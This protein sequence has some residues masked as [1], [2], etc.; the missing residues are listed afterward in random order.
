MRPLNIEDLLGR[1]TVDT[2][3]K[4]ENNYIN[5]NVVL[6]TGAGGSIGSELCQQ[7][8]LQNPSKLI[9]LDASEFNL[10]NIHQ[11]ISEKFNLGILIVPI[12]G[13]V[14]NKSAMENIFSKYKPDIIYHAAAYKHVPLVQFNPV[15]GIINNVFGTKIIADLSLKYKAKKLVLI[16]TDKAVRPTNIMGASKRL[17]ELYLQALN[18]K[19]MSTIFTMV[20]FGNVLGSSGSVIPKFHQQ[21]L[22]GKP[23]TLTHKKVTRFFMTAKEAIHLIIEAGNLAKGGD[24]FIL[25]MGKP[26]KIF[27]LAKND[28]FIRKI[29]KR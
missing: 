13:S 12:L 15:E 10:Y 16:S 26:I 19:K 7:V 1:R 23:I 3:F 20:R 14:T 18:N 25:E 28:F 27:N 5:Q 17:A 2:S 21:I 22:D 11:I 29:P 9:I 6:I 8:L 4:K 24:V